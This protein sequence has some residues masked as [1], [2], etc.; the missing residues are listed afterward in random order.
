MREETITRVLQGLTVSLNPRGPLYKY[1]R[2]GVDNRRRLSHQSRAHV[3]PID[4]STSEPG[5]KA[6]F[7]Y[8]SPINRFS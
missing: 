1:S 5:S 3:S 7:L 8:I 6:L 2:T 4:M